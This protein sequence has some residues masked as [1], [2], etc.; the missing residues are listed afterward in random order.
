MN[1]EYIFL[2]F[3]SLGSRENVLL[4][5]EKKQIILCI[6]YLMPNLGDHI[7]IMAKTTFKNFCFHG[8]KGLAFGRLPKWS[9]KSHRWALILIQISP[10]IDIP[11]SIILQSDI[12]NYGPFQ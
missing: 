10:N 11:T 12:A 5:Y 8:K 6:L 4:T 7:Y 9:I 3:K 2:S 1:Q